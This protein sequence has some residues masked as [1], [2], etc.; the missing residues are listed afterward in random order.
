MH[1]IIIHMLQVDD[2]SFVPLENTDFQNM[3]LKT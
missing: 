2:N 3:M 1:P